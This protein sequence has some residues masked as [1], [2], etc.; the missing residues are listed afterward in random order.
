VAA[1]AGS[2]AQLTF[3]KAYSGAVGTARGSIHGCIEGEQTIADVKALLDGSWE[4]PGLVVD[5]DLR[6]RLIV[7]LCAAGVFGETE[8]SAELER[9]TTIS[10]KEEAAGARAAMPDP[11]VKAE[12]WRL[13]MLDAATPNGT[14]ASIAYEFARTGQ[15]AL[16]GYIQAFLDAAETIWENLGTHRAATAMEYIFP[17]QLATQANLDLIDS[18]LATSTASAGARRYA[19]EGRDELARALRAQ[20][21]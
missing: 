8:I 2:D 18:W 1:E 6:W 12:A 9:D 3:A 7:G 15:P 16:D 10:G 17:R 4:L 20:Q 13:A 11:A 14:G 5:Q 21:A 19:A